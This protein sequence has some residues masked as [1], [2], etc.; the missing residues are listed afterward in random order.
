MLLT[1]ALIGMLLV[2]AICRKPGIP[3]FTVIHFS[4]RH[5]KLT[6][7]GAKLYVVAAAMIVLGFVASLVHP[8]TT[9]LTEH[10]ETV[11]SSANTTVSEEDRKL[12]LYRALMWQFS[13]SAETLASMMPANGMAES[14]LELCNSFVEAGTMDW[15]QD[16]SVHRLRSAVRDCHHVV[17]DLCR[18]AGPEDAAHCSAYKRRTEQFDYS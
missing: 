15:K 13:I 5:A 17:L 9:E 7:T 16:H 12:A 18:E 8:R 3:F 1:L 2:L 10:A 4:N 11:D 6:S 14:R